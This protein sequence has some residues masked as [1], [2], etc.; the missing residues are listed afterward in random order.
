MATTKVVLHRGG[1]HC[2]RV[3]FKVK[4]PESVV[5]W[6]CNCSNCLMRRNVHFIVPKEDFELEESS[7]EFLTEYTFNT[8]TAKHLFCKVCGITSFYI[9]RSNQ[10]GFAVTVNCIDPGT[11][12]NVEVKTYDGV[13]WEA[14][15]DNSGIAAMSKPA[16][17]PATE[18]DTWSSS[19]QQLV[20]VYTDVS[21]D[22]DW[23]LLQF[24]FAI[25][26][27][28]PCYELGNRFQES[29]HMF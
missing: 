24:E 3:R 29:C 17:T 16:I 18:T 9:P 20:W 27:Q 10:D 12:T 25:C 5:V 28:I 23:I 1:C 19:S 13:N 11:I 2:Q 22:F 21:I 4:A 14:N 6:D 7:K 15:Y 26:L 8:H